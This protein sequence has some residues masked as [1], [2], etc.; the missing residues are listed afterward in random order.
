MMLTQKEKYLVRLLQKSIPLESQ[1]FKSIGDEI[2]MTEDEVL[3]KIKQWFSDGLI[4]RF[5]GTV[6]HKK[7]GRASNVMSV[8]RV[9]P[10]KIKQIAHIASSFDQI[11]HCYERETAPGW[12][13]NFYAMIH[14]ETEQQCREIAKIIA[15]HSGVNDYELL[16]SEEE[17]KKESMEFF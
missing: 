10:D 6:S 8:W 5:G 7:V 16:F 2:G 14:C 1:P 11:T 9:E 15:E 13:Y 12:R 3:S 17:Y 4:R